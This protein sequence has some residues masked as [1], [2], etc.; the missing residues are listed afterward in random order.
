MALSDLFTRLRRHDPA[1]DDARGVP[2]QTQATKALPRFLSALGSRAQ[3]VLLDLGS[4]A[5]SNLT[6]FGEQLGCKIFVEDLA[7]DIDRYVREN[8]TGELA[9]FLRGRFPQPDASFDG[10][11]CWDVFDYLDKTAA[12]ALAPQL[13]RLLRPDGV[14][15]AFFNQTEAIVN[16]PP[17]YTRHVVIDPRTLEHR[18]QAAVRGKQRPLNN[19]DIQ[20]MF[21]PLRISDQFLLKTNMREVV[22]RKPAPAVTPPAAVPRPAS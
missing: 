12:Q 6:F 5:G 16:A 13:V 11:I 20:R 19:R 9:E 15:L 2:V 21:E 14:M 18:T 7:K 3:P 17:T 8:R 1:S 22:F 4:I 10:I